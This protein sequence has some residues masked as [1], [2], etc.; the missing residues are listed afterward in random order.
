MYVNIY[1]LIMFVYICYFKIKMSLLCLTDEILLFVLNKLSNT[2]VLYSL[3]GVNKRFKKN[4]LILFWNNTLNKRQYSIFDFGY[5]PNLCQLTLI[6][7]PFE[8]F[9]D[10]FDGLLLIY[11]EKSSF[12]NKYKYQISYLMITIDDHV[13]YL[14]IRKDSKNSFISIVNS[15]ENLQHLKF[16][17]EDIRTHSSLSFTYPSLSFVLSSTIWGCWGWW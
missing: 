5:Y 9:P 2:D 11:L 13:E 12:I 1:W 6:K 10:M 14:K 7:I 17:F 16:D 8:I 3:I 15:F 4:R